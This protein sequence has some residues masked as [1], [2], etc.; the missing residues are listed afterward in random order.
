M[1]QWDVPSQWEIPSERLHLS[2]CL[3]PAETS[4]INTSHSQITTQTQLIFRTMS[5]LEFWTDV[6]KLDR[7]Q[8]RQKNMINLEGNQ[9]LWPTQCVFGEIVVAP[10]CCKQNIVTGTALS[11]HSRE[12]SVC[13]GSKTSAGDPSPSC[14]L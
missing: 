13:L 9:Q 4:D 10:S 5:S 12:G 7:V 2:E 6:Y 8:R 1:L 11:F 14:G 3:S